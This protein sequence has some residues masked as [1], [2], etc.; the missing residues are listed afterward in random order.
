MSTTNDASDSSLM[1][2]GTGIVIGIIVFAVAAVG[3]FF[4]TLFG[5]TGG[6]IRDEGTPVHVQRNA[7]EDRPPD[8]RILIDMPGSAEDAPAS[9]PR[10]P[11]SPEPTPSAPEPDTEAPSAEADPDPVAGS[12]VLQVSP[13]V[14]DFGLQPRNTL[15][16]GA[17]GLINRTPDPVR[18]GPATTTCQCSTLETDGL[19]V[20][21]GGTLPVPVTLETGDLRGPRTATVRIPLP[22][23]P[24]S[25]VRFE[26]V[27][28]VGSTVHATPA[29][30][31]AIDAASGV[32][33]VEAD[34]GRPF[35]IRSVNGGPAPYVDFDPET[36]EPR[37]RYELA[38]DLSDLD[39]N[40]CRHADGRPFRPVWVIATDHPRTPV[41]DLRVR[42]L[43]TLRM[44]QAPGR[45]WILLEPRLWLGT[46]RPNGS[47]QVTLTLNYP[48]TRRVTDTVRRA[49]LPHPDLDARIVASDQTHAGRT[50]LTIAVTATPD[51]AP[52]VIDDVLIVEGGQGR[53]SIPIV[54]RLTGSR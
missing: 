49:F 9:P 11:A 32:F 20:P 15:L 19:V 28:E 3:Y 35:R 44:K 39:P 36:D 41:F 12:L 54:G 22:D 42:H 30:I 37:A 33:V 52:G 17:V 2:S 43:C 24:E 4:A 46:M 10:S 23:H 38:W 13:A 25:I 34:D 45:D 50:T 14:V 1:T 18:L 6:G 53:E 29:A 48:R 31:Q 40:T 51:A 21:P 7:S 16:R 5:I 27:S 8:G 47:R 26:V